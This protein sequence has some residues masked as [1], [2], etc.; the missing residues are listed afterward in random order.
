MERAYAISTDMLRDVAQATIIVGMPIVLAAWL[1]G[2][3][4]LAVDAR[5]QLAPFLREHPGLAYGVVAALSV[6]IIAWGPMPATRSPIPVLAMVGLSMAGLEVLRR[7]T[8][9]EFPPSLSGR[10]RRP[11]AT[12]IRAAGAARRGR[13][14]AHADRRAGHVSAAPLRLAEPPPEVFPAPRGRRA[15]ARGLVE[16]PRLARRLVTSSAPIALLVA[17]A[18][19]GKSALLAQWEARDERPF[20]WASLPARATAAGGAAGAV[21]AALRGLGIVH[22]AGATSASALAEAWAGAATAHVLVLDGA[23]VLDDEAGAELLGA[24]AE[25][26]PPGSTLAVASRSEPRLP[27]GRLRTEDAV[28]ELRAPTCAMTDREAALLLRRAGLRLDAATTS[29]A[30]TRATE[31]WPAALH[32]AGLALREQR[33]LGRR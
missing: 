24:L 17:P 8:A 28:V 13:R 1:A 30:G 26:V 3:Q 5:R 20:A 19:Y 12:R 6:L 31:G 33:D 22:D 14:R 18:G 27:V 21:A 9:T 10:R 25:H 29:L 15:P 11:A 23:D 2:P 32:L 4:R 16:R 7:Q